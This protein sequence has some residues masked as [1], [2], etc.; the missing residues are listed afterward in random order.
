MHFYW[1]YEHP[2]MNTCRGE[3]PLRLCDRMMANGYLGWRGPFLDPSDLMTQRITRVSSLICHPAMRGRTTSREQKPLGAEPASA[4]CK[5]NKGPVSPEWLHGAQ[6][7]WGLSIR[8]I[9]LA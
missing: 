7:A 4:C 9:P 2:M 3:V 5:L 8:R 1:P 6:W